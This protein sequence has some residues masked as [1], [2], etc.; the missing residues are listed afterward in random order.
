MSPYE[1]IKWKLLTPVPSNDSI[2]FHGVKAHQ[3][4]GE[5]FW[6]ACSLMEATTSSNQY[7]SLPKIK[8]KKSYTNFI[9]STYVC[10]INW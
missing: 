8:N 6:T 4:L 1:F 5:E 2:A 3:R 7:Y 9:N 10:M